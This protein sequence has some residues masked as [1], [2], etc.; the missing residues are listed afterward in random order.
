MTPLLHAVIGMMGEL[1]ELAGALEKAIWYGQKFDEANF[2][3]ELGDLN[4]Y[5]AEALNELGAKFE[6]VLARNIEKLQI[7]YPE[8]FTE[9]RAEER[10]R[11][12]NAERDVLED[13]PVDD[14]APELR[15]PGYW[16]KKYGLEIMDPDGW[17]GRYRKSLNEPINLK[18]F[19][20]RYIRSSI[21]PWSKPMDAGLRSLYDPKYFDRDLPSGTAYRHPT[22]AITHDAPVIQTGAGW[23]EPSEDLEKIEVTPEY[24]SNRIYACGNCGFH[25]HVQEKIQI[26][27]R[28]AHSSTDSSLIISD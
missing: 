19:I 8:K 22:G 4:W 12:R 2:K 16:C 23:G 26:C 9:A 7:R 27:T 13:A 25:L 10:N 5:Q 24:V 17:A 3:E 11:D 1:G 18:E 6:D 20:N 14:V 15:I 21:D 28:C